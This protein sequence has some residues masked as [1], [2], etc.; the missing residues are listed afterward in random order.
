MKSYYCFFDSYFFLLF[1]YLFLL[2]SYL[3]LLLSH[4]FH[5]FS[6]LGPLYLSAAAEE[7]EEIVEEKNLEIIRS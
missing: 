4:F 1:S 2:Y 7:M 6:S 5:P 3:F